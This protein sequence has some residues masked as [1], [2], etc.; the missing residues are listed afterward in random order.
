M[1]SSAFE[2]VD[3]FAFAL[4]RDDFDLAISMLDAGCIYQA[5]TE[6]HQGAEAVIQSFKDATEWAHKNL[7]IIVYLHSIE[8]CQDCT[9]R[10]RFVDEVSHQGKQMQHTC[11]MHVTVRDD[12]K[13]SKLRL[14]DLDGEKQ[15]V[16]DFLQAAGIKR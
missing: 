11:L 10:I 5:A 9:A 16:S 15:K 2:F 1:K 4:D 3:Q 7:D 12:N 13:I 6:A 14:E 8:Q